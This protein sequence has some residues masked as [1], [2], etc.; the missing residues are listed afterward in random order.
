MIAIDK[1]GGF[2][3]AWVRYIL[4]AQEL[5]Q[6]VDTFRFTWET[7][8]LKLGTPI[9]NE[10]IQGMISKCKEFLLQAN[11]IVHE[12]SKKWVAEFQ[13]ALKE[14]DEAAKAAAEVA[15]RRQK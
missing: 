1:L 6:I 9:N 4:A 10:E 11:V 12:E 7:E 13:T 15:K 3:I 8:K 14:V 5:D 2:T